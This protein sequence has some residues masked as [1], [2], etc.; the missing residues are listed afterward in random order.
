VKR[1][2]FG[3]RHFRQL[4]GLAKETNRF[5]GDALTKRGEAHDPARSLDQ[6]QPKRAFQLAQAGRKR[7]LSD[8]ASLGGLAEVPV[9]TQ[10]DQILQLLER[11]EVDG[12]VNRKPQLARP[13]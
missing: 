8:E 4:F 11:G 13:L 3:P 5:V 10:R 2:P 1:L 7:R 9:L 12:H 6:G